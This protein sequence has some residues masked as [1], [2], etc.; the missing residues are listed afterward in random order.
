MAR[1]FS[2][3][4]THGLAGSPQ[5]A[6]G[7]WSD[8]PEAAFN[9][10]DVSVYFNDFNTGFSSFDLTNDWLATLVNGAAG[11]TSW[12]LGAAQAST[13]P[14]FVGFIF[15]ASGTVA[16]SGFTLGTASG[17]GLDGCFA[18]PAITPYYPT[19]G[20]TVPA[21]ANFI[22][23]ETKVA[24]TTANGWANTSW[25]FGLANTATSTTIPISSTG[26][27]SAGTTGLAGFNHVVAS[28]TGIPTLSVAGST[29]TVV[30]VTPDRPI[31][32]GVQ[33]TALVDG[34]RR[35]GIRIE[36]QAATSASSGQRVFFYLDGLL[37]ARFLMTSAMG[38]NNIKPVFS[39]MN[40]SAGQVTTTFRVD[41]LSY[42][43]GRA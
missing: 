26:V 42:A 38:A 31:T 23:Y 34:S 3:H 12:S 39:V 28:G 32:A 4:V 15:V 27:V 43:A 6:G 11:G 37:R 8:A 17:T 18:S 40:N 2:Q 16:S 35:F 9:N 41:W 10:R 22:A 20:I 33:N 24:C 13:T 7:L 1:Q 30:A 19:S 14:Q 25:F 5:N 21:A 29:G 36:T